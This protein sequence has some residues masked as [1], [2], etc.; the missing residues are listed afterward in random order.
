[1]K[2]L[3]NDIVMPPIGKLIGGIDFASFKY[4]IQPAVEDE[5]VTEIAIRYGLFINNIITFMIV[6]SAIFMIVRFY[7][8]VKDKLI[9]E[10]ED[11][12]LPKQKASNEETLLT[13]IRDLLKNK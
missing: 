2:S 12:V 10:E 8:K 13:E 11:A 1:M 5:G 4:I 9:H 7:N 6:A 3:V